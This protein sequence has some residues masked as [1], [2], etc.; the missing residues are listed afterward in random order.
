MSNREKN[1]K[2]NN[3][4]ILNILQITVPT[5]STSGI[6][7]SDCSSPVNADQDPYPGPDPDKILKLNCWSKF[8]SI[9]L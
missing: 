9:H 3:Q 7:F 4:K 1:N 2:E 6:L 5:V 8:Q